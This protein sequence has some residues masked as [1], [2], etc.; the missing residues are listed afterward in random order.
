ML[1]GLQIAA[2]IGAVVL[3]ILGIVYF[4]LWL[5]ATDWL[6]G[7]TQGPPAYIITALWAAGAGLVATAI[8]LVLAVVGGIRTRAPIGQGRGRRVV[9][10]AAGLV[11]LAIPTALIAAIGISELPRA[12]EK[13][14]IDRIKSKRATVSELVEALNDPEPLTRWEAARGLASMGPTAEPAIGPLADAVRRGTGPP[15]G[16]ADPLR[17][18]AGEALAKIGPAAVPTL[19]ELLKDPSPFVRR[20]AARAL[21][22]IGRPAQAAVPA[23]NEALQDDD[24]Q[25]RNLARVALRAIEA[26]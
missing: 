1:R 24:E 4:V 6:F 2:V 13:A 16:E 9:W 25:T 14:R 23:L 5:G 20:T 21:A 26:N 17:M 7:H 18:H 22:G 19:V 15:Y 11:L 10:Q 8:W 3:D 12:Q